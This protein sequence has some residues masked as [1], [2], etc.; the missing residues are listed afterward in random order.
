METITEVKTIYVT[1]YKAVNGTIFNTEQECI[2]YEKQC[3]EQEAI[4]K[5][6]E[7]KHIY[8]P[9]VALWD[10]EIN[11]SRLYILKSKADYEALKAHF[12]DG[13]DYWEEPESFPKVM[14]VFSKNRCHSVGYVIDR[15]RVK[16]FEKLLE[17]ICAYLYKI[18]ES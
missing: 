2:D 14:A 7:C 9:F 8:E 6:I 1:K 4:Y 10:S 11:I 17:D 3:L 18:K 13:V 16:Y 5:A 15:N 12:I